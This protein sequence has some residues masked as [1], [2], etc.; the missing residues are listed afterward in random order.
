VDNDGNTP[1]WW[2][3]KEKQEGCI[4]LLL[5]VGVSTEEATTGDLSPMGFQLRYLEHF[6]DSCG[7][8]AAL[9]GKSTMD[10]VHQHVKPR[11]LATSGQGLSLCE[12]LLREGSPLVGPATWFGTSQGLGSGGKGV[13]FSVAATM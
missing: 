12:Q 1:L 5:E 8:R 4:Q 3:T 11:T 7:G 9:Q 10:V 2:A 6:V 13:C